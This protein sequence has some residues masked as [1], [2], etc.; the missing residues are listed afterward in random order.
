MSD[1]IN[2]FFGEYRWLSNFYD[3]DIVYEDI[4]FPSVEHAYVYSKY[5]TKPKELTQFLEL[6]SGQVKRLGKT[7]DIRSDF[8]EIK[9]DVMA[10]LIFCKFSDRNPELVQKL[11]STGEAH[12]S[13][14]NSWGDTFWGVNLEGV[15]LNMLGKIIMARR[16]QLQK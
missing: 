16:E 14:T 2:G 5:N 9:V 10:E 11:L 12:I 4:Y 3:A 7:I 1:I 13:E 15:G 8:D 6:T